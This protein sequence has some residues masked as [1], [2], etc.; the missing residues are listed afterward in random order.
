M[1]DMEHVPIFDGLELNIYIYTHTQSH[2]HAEQTFP[3]NL[4]ILNIGLPAFTKPTP[5]LTVGVSE[6]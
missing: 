6:G 1:M 3:D 5:P 2:T 4:Y